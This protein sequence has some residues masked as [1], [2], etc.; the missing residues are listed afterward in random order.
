MA[1]AAACGTK[2]AFYFNRK[3]KPDTIIFCPELCKSM[4][5]GKIK[6]IYGCLP[7]IG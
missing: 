2:R 3:D 4:K 5:G 7:D 1:D 6:I